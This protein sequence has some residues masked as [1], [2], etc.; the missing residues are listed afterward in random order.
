LALDLIRSEPAVRAL[1][2]RRLAS[3]E[4]GDPGKASTEASTGE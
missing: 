1:F 2:E 4:A 3:H